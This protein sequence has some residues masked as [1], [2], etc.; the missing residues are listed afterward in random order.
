[1]FDDCGNVVF[2]QGAQHSV[3]FPIMPLTFLVLCGACVPIYDFF[4]VI[5]LLCVCTEMNV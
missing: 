3:T 5:I 1:M 4:A 2:P